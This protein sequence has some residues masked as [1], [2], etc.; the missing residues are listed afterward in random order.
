MFLE[1]AGN[2]QLRTL[3]HIHLPLAHT[4]SSSSNITRIFRHHCYPL[5]IILALFGI[6]TNDLVI[7]SV[8]C[9]A[10]TLHGENREGLFQ[11]YFQLFNA[12]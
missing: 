5:Y 4:H 12:K 7:I 10:E 2:S 8:N 1:V 6:P 3:Y 9:I 11:P